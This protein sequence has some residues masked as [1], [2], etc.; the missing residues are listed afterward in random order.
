[1]NFPSLLL[2]IH[3]QSAHSYLHEK[4]LLSLYLWTKLLKRSSAIVYISNNILDTNNL[5]IWVTQKSLT[6]F[7][8]LNIYLSWNNLSYLEITKL[9]TVLMHQACFL[10]HGERIWSFMVFNPKVVF[11]IKTLQNLWEVL[12]FTMIKR[13]KKK[14]QRSE[15]CMK[16]YIHEVYKKL[17]WQAIDNSST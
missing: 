17:N 11:C 12:Q 5:F 1:M 14:Y 9:K 10:A 13:N 7:A 15:V 4:L 16:L 6:G 3:T 8:V 2:P